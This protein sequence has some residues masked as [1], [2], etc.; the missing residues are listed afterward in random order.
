VSDASADL[1]FMGSAQNFRLYPLFSKIAPTVPLG[2]SQQDYRE[3]GILDV[4]R[5]LGIEE[6]ARQRLA[7]YRRCVSEAR[8]RL[9]VAHDQT[10]IFLR[11]RRDTCVVYTQKRMFGRLLFEHLGLVPDAAMP[12]AGGSKGWDVLSLERLSTVR[13]EHIFMV[14][15]RDSEHY[16]KSV[17]DSPIWQ[18]IP[19]V[20]HHHVHRV[21]T[22]TWLGGEG[23]LDSEAII[24]DVL[25]AMTPQG[26]S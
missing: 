9:A 10:V 14:V 17:S 22:G 21:D 12:V 8:T 11:F 26:G 5:V 24:R 20:Q 2:S 7:A 18:E 6:Q 13:A 19:A 3:M 4:G 23:V 25:A 16:L 1:I 15:D